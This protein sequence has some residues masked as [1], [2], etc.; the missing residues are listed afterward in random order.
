MIIS[1]YVAYTI[2]AVQYAVEVEMEMGWWLDELPV[3]ARG[4]SQHRT[5][6]RI[7]VYESTTNQ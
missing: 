6:T 1:F 2:A 7:R 4:R 3:A 5:P